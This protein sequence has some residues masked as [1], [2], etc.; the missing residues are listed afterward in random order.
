[1]Y[2]KQKQIKEEVNLYFPKRKNDWEYNML[3]CKYNALRLGGLS[4]GETLKK[5]G[6]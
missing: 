3:R 4:K 5:M 2:L 6:F 1:M